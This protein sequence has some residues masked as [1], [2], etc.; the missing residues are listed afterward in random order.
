MT[1]MTEMTATEFKKKLTKALGK[2][3]NDVIDID[4]IMETMQKIKITKKKTVKRAL[5]PYNI[6]M[7]DTMKQVKIDQPDLPQMDVMRESVRLWKL[8]KDKD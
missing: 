8:Q 2:L 3:V 4:S 6:F 1:E 5:T 7:K